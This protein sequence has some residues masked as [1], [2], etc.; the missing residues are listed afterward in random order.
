M[1]KHSYANFETHS[2]WKIIEDAITELEENKDLILQTKKEYVCGFI[3]KQLV[4][5]TQ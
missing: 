2:Y 4:K 5:S 3:V 1:K